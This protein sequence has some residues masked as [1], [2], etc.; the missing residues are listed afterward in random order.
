MKKIIFIC[1]GGIGNIIQATPTIKKLSEKYIIDLKLECN[2]S[3]DVKEIFSLPKI[4]NIVKDVIDTYDYQLN[5]PFTSGAKYCEKVIRSRIN[6]AQHVPE[7]EVYNDLAVQIG[8]NDTIGNSVICIPKS[9]YDPPKNSVIIYPGSKHNWAMKRWD[10]Y[11][12]L[13]H[14]LKNYKHVIV[15]GTER[16]VTSH[17]D[18]AWIKKPWEW[19]DEVEFFQGTLSETAYVISKCDFFIGND[20][21]IAHLSGATGIPTFVLFGPSSDIKNKPKSDNAHVIAMNLPCRP[22]QFKKKDGKLI[23]NG[24]IGNCYNNMKCMKDM[25]VEYIIREL[26]KHIA[27]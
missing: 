1:A 7:C 24:D 14:V 16:D 18:P 17:G 11:D 22:C 5:G 21:G 13:S 9:G 23:F 2:S 3:N 25:S 6:Y 15:V 26:K 4:R 20:G 12:Q 27:L 19:A 8:C 10:K